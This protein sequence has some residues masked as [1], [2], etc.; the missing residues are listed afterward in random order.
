[1][2][3]VDSVTGEENVNGALTGAYFIDMTD[4]L[5]TFTDI[6]V[7]NCIIRNIGRTVL[8][9]DRQAYTGNGFEF[10]NC[11]IY[12]QRDDDFDNYGPFRL[13][14]TIT[15][16]YFK[17]TNSTIYNVMGRTLD[18]ENLSGFHLDVTVDQCTF[19]A[20]HGRKP[21]AYI[22]DFKLAQDLNLSVTNCIFS[23]I[24]PGDTIETNFFRFAE[25]AGTLTT[26]IVTSAFYDLNIVGGG[27]DEVVWDQKQYV[28]TDDPEFVD[29]EKGDFTLSETSPYL[30]A[31]LDLTPIGDLR[32]T[33]GGIEFMNS[34]QSAKTLN[35]Y[36][37]PAS[38]ILNVKS[39]MDIYIGIYTITGLLVK[40]VYLFK[41]N[42]IIDVSVLKSG[43]YLMKDG[44]NLYSAKIAIK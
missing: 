10:D 29:P 31:S 37:N 36:P 4:S 25:D 15:F 28:Y 35:I 34:N 38:Q 12:D 1:G 26:S 32:W 11:I 33:P 42:N 39:D 13:N 5:K 9:G 30:E 20:I 17:L 3:D 19:Y 43:L 14:K 8:R 22:V 44:H 16:N 41:G 21:L 7:R 2:Y 6:I 24:N 18:F 27:V 40:R 23:N